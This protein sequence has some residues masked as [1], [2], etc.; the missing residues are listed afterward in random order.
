MQVPSPI[1]QSLRHRE[2]QLECQ[3]PTSDPSTTHSTANLVL[4]LIRVGSG[5]RIV[6]GSNCQPVNCR[7][8]C[9]QRPRHSVVLHPRHSRGLVHESQKTVGGPPDKTPSAPTRENSRQVLRRATTL[10]WRFGKSTYPRRIVDTIYD[11]TK[12]MFFQHLKRYGE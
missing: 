1:R 7:A 3:K 9:Q 5:A 2:Q 8:L 6:S 4:S 11:E 10:F 12:T